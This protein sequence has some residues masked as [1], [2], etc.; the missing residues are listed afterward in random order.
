VHQV[1]VADRLP[2]RGLED[3]SAL[4]QPHPAADDHLLVGLQL[5]GQVG[6]VE[7]HHP[8]IAAV[9]THYGFGAPPPPQPYLLSLPDI[10]DYGLL[11]T[12]GEL[13]DGVALAVVQVAMGEEVKQVAHR[14]H[15]QLLEPGRHG[16]AD[17]LDTGDRAVERLSR[18]RRRLLLYGCAARLRRGFGFF[19]F[20]A[21]RLGEKLQ[22]LAY[23][24]LTLRL[25]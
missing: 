24:L 12:L 18:K 20:I 10:G 3:I 13:G 16:L 8:H 15:P 11:L 5:L 22:Y 17:T 14:A 9:I 23:P 4:V 6:V 1:V 21:R 19:L 7:P 2:L 25:G